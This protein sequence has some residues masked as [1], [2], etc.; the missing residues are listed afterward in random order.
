MIINSKKYSKIVIFSVIFILIAI[1][2]FLYTID[3]YNIRH[4]KAKQYY[5][6]PNQ[7]VLIVQ[8]LLIDKYYK[9]Y[10]SYIFGSSRV[11]NINPLLIK[12]YKTYNMT[13]GEGIPH[14]H[15]LIIKLFLRN[16]VPIKHL[17]IGLDEF[18]YQVPFSLHDNQ[19]GAK[20]HYLATKISLFN[21]YKF[22]FFH[23]PKLK[24]F[25]HLK[26]K[27]NHKAHILSTLVYNEI[28]K[29][30]EVYSNVK[31]I[32]DHTEE[33]INNPKFSLPTLYVGNELKNTLEDIK[34]IV[35]IAKKNNIELHI[36][37][38]PIHHTTYKFT[39]KKL[40]KDFKEKL[41]HITS[42][43]DFAL[44][45]YIT[46]NNAYWYD[47]SHYNPNIG[48]MIIS[49]IYDKNSTIKNFGI[50]VKKKD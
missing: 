10:N 12:N 29:Q 26:N 19:F 36:F 45:S 1:T 44:P 6:I 48:N 2:L 47:T 18:S 34:K 23:E 17:L 46:K 50:F 33:H 14:E 15:L 49:K 3:T 43:Y 24:D 37:I 31:A 4:P 7:R 9:N 28:F 32:N 25:K 13:Y 21:F 8:H 27:L 20:S 42:Y 5:T 30:K 40:L 16:G 22:Y 39:N 35:N 38:N 11:G 41:S